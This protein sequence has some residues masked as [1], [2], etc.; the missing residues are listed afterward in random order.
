MDNG[1][2]QHSEAYMVARRDNRHKRTGLGWR[3]VPFRDTVEKYT[4]AKLTTKQRDKLPDSSF[5]L[6]SQRAYPIHDENHARSALQLVAQHGTPEEKSK[7]R[8]AVRRRYPNMKV[9]TRG[10]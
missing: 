10:S 4:E 1:Y 3:P 2:D 8:A 6:P 7:V 5:A 9:G